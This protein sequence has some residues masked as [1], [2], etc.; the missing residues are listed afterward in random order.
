MRYAVVTY[1]FEFSDFMREPEVKDYNAD[2]FCL[3]DNPKLKKILHWKPVYVSGLDGMS[4]EQKKNSIKFSF[5]DYI[6]NDY[7]YYVLVDSA[8]SI[9]FSLL[10]IVSFVNSNNYSAMFSLHPNNS[11][12]LKEYDDWISIYNL[13]QKYK[14]IFMDCAEMCDYNLDN[15][16]GVIETAFMVLKNTPEVIDFIREV[17]RNMGTACNFEDKNDQCWFTFIYNVAYSDKINV[18]LCCRQL[19]YSSI[20]MA[21]YERKSS[22]ICGAK[23]SVF[24]NPFVLNGKPRHI[25]GF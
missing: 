11:D 19:Y 25:I 5:M 2:Y 13:D 4:Y 15:T 3:T 1:I 22:K 12:M 6:P 20:Y 17:H 9:K 18:C 14:R 21:V 7:D 23:Y 16:S 24:S 8:I 10:P